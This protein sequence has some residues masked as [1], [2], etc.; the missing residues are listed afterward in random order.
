MGEGESGKEEEQ[1]TL[2]FNGSVARRN[3]AR[4]NIVKD[5]IRKEREGKGE[6]KEDRERGRGQRR[7][8]FQSE[9]LVWKNWA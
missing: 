4:T 2:Y 1:T 9:L 3:L 8:D 7:I 5:G 6:K